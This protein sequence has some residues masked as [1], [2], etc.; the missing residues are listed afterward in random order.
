[1]LGTCTT[2]SSLVLHS[3]ALEEGELYDPQQ[4][5]MHDF[6]GFVSEKSVPIF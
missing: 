5:V 3:R 4:L 2:L 6:S 1:M